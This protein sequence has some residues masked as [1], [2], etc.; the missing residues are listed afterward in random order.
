MKTNKYFKEWLKTTQG[1]VFSDCAI[2]KKEQYRH[3]LEDRLQ[4]AFEAGEVAYA[5]ET[6]DIRLRHD[7]THEEASVK[8]G[9]MD[10]RAKRISPLMRGYNS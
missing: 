5:Q 10:D 8:R 3:V 9:R 6:I 1:M 7:D 2:L 4:A